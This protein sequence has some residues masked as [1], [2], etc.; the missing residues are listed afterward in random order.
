MMLKSIIKIIC[1]VLTL[2]LASN[3]T[4]SQT[5]YETKGINTQKNQ[6][7]RWHNDADRAD[8]DLRKKIVEGKKSDRVKNSHEAIEEFFALA[9]SLEASGDY[10]NAAKCYEKILALTRDP[11]IRKYIKKKN[12]RLKKLSK[13]QRALTKKK[14]KESTKK[15]TSKKRDLKREEEIANKKKAKIERIDR[16]RKK[17][18]EKIEKRRRKD[19]ERI[20]GKKKLEELE[21]AKAAGLPSPIEPEITK[22]IEGLPEVK[23]TPSSAPVAI[24]AITQEI[25]QKRAEEKAI[26]NKIEKAKLLVIEGDKMYQKRKYEEAFELYREAMETLR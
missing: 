4:Y 11:N 1:L 8:R 16:Q 14:I 22:A 9:K 10:A 3:L 6:I 24:E 12:R 13:R 17:E 7:R 19:I 25:I 5:I 23:V 20:I 21:K 15:L 18:L 2:C 26:E